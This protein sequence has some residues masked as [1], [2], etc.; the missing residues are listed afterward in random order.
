MGVEISAPAGY[1]M[2]LRAEFY[3]DYSKEAEALPAIGEDIHDLLKPQ[4]MPLL[5]WIRNRNTVSTIT[6]KL[7][8]S[9]PEFIYRP[10]GRRVTEQHPTLPSCQPSVRK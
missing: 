7:S 5:R 9:L 4:K 3:V 2:R 10:P 8:V 6:S 1:G